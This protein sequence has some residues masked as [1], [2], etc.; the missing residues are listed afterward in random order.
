[1]SRVTAPVAKLS[2]AISTTAAP[3]AAV[4]RNHASLLDSTTHNGGAALM[5]KYA[6]LLRDREQKVCF[7]FLPW[8]GISQHCPIFFKSY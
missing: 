7:F 4:A 6:E 2:R 8:M 1:M 5:P 3:A